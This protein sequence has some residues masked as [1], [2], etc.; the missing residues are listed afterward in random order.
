MICQRCSFEWEDKH[1]SLLRCPSCKRNHI[2]TKARFGRSADGALRMIPLNEVE[3]D[4]SD[5]IFS[6]P[7]DP[8]FG[9]GLVR[10]SVTLLGGGEGAGKSTLALQLANAISEVTNKHV[11]YFATEEANK[12]IRPRAERLKLKRIGQIHITDSMPED[13]YEIL[14][15]LNEATDFPSLVI[16]DS[17]TGLM[18]INL[19]GSVELCKMLK[20]WASDVECPV[21]LV[22]HLNKE[23][24]FVGLRTLQYF[25]DS[26]LTLTVNEKQPQYRILKVYK[27][28]FGPG[29][30]EVVFRMS[31]RGLK[32]TS[33]KGDY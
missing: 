6:G 16:L 27:T 2:S 17:L 21:V 22:E 4:D 5:R 23:D 31:K 11:Y 3:A 19:Q 20:L 9:G 10:S 15:V 25:V 28:R 33:Q 1:G 14:N 29:D 12:Q 8:C 24:D 7:W 30:I 18:G 32:V 26:T 13:E